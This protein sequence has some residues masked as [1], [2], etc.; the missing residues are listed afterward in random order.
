L[1]SQCARSAAM[2]VLCVAKRFSI[3]YGIAAIQGATITTV[4]EKAH[5]LRVHAATDALCAARSL[6]QVVGQTRETSLRVMS[7]MAAERRFMVQDSRSGRASVLLDSS[8]SG[9]EDLGGGTDAAISRV[10]SVRCRLTRGR[11]TSA[12]SLCD[13]LEGGCCRATI[14][15]RFRGE[16]TGSEAREE[17]GNETVEDVRPAAGFAGLVTCIKE[18]AI[19]AVGVAVLVDLLFLGERVLCL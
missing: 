1:R 17:S 4:L 5:W 13:L 19:E 3:T 8:I 11:S 9:D 16:L 18:L 7:A 6:L 12:G 10:G 15:G 14:R 2:V